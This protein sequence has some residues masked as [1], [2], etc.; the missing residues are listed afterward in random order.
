MVNVLDH[1]V[2]TRS[3]RQYFKTLLMQLC[4]LG[5]AALLWNGLFFSCISLSYKK[6]NVWL[7]SPYSCLLS[8]LSLI[9]L[10][11][12]EWV[13]C[14]VIGEWWIWCLILRWTFIAVCCHEWKDKQ[15]MLRDLRWMSVYVHIPLVEQG[16]QC[17]ADV[18]FDPVV[19]SSYSVATVGCHKRRAESES[20]EDR[21]E[22]WSDGQVRW[23]KKNPH[24]F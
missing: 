24:Y 15:E 2:E 6:Q 18:H 8:S 19:C 4:P 17:V 9:L 13:F 16:D 10:Y 1:E 5:R 12:Y 3:M 14:S 23:K 21:T 7:F 22:V 20:V 11:M